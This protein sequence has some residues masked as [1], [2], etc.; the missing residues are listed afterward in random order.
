M[1]TSMLNSWIHDYAVLRCDR[2]HRTG[3]GVAVF[4]RNSITYSVILSESINN[5]Y[6]ILAADLTHNNLSF[7]IALVY[8]PPSIP[9]LLNERTCKDLP[10]I[11]IGDFNIPDIDWAA[12]NTQDNNAVYHDVLSDILYF[13][14]YQQYVKD[15]TRGENFLDLVFANSTELLRNVK[16]IAPIGDSDHS[17]ISFDILGSATRHTPI[18]CKQFSN[19]D[20]NSIAT[21]LHNVS[22]AD[23]FESVSSVDEKYRMFL[24]I[25]QH[26]IQIFVP[27]A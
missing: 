1:V 10:C 13:H 24:F 2:N 4:L 3:G 8:R 14:G 5:G 9:S 17:C 25:L 6:E 18:L 16:V 26:T 21:Y 12:W 15:P 27:S 19:C 20:Y 22:W 7:R 11:V 23:S